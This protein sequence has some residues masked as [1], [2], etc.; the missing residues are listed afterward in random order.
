MSP[1][2]LF[3]Y[4]A[5]ELPVELP[6]VSN[7]ERG[8]RDVIADGECG[9]LGGSDS[10]SYTLRTVH[11]AAPEQ[12]RIWGER[13]REVIVSRFSRSVAVRRLEKILEVAEQKGKVS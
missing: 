2:K 5:S 13:G 3:D 11:D 10:L 6:V 9:P 12:R 7:A 1:N 4:L 8:F